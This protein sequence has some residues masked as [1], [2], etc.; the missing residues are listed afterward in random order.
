MN[1][2][3]IVSSDQLF[4]EVDEEL[5]NLFTD[6]LAM[7]FFDN[8]RITTCGH[9]FSANMLSTWFDTKNKHNKSN[10]CSCPLCKKPLRYNIGIEDD[11]FL[12]DIKP[13]LAIQA[14]GRIIKAVDGSTVEKFPINE[15]FIN[16]FVDPISLD[17]I[18]HPVIATCCG[19]LHDNS[20]FS[21]TVR[22][23]GTCDKQN[24]A[25]V[26][27]FTV[28]SILQWMATKNIDLAPHY[29]NL[30][31]SFYAALMAND[32]KQVGLLIDKMDILAEVP[33]IGSDNALHISIRNGLDEMVKLLA[34]RSVNLDK[35]D[36]NGYP[37][38]C[39]AVQYNRVNIVDMLLI[40]G[41]DPERE[42]I[43][44]GNL[45]APQL[46]QQLGLTE[47]IVLFY[48]YYY[49]PDENPQYPLAVE[50]FNRYNS[51]GIGQF[52]LY[53]DELKN[54]NSWQWQEIICGLVYQSTLLVH[55][56]H[57]I[58]VMEELV[59]YATYYERGL[60]LIQACE[61][62]LRPLVQLLFKW[63]CDINAFS[64]TGMRAIFAAI[65]QNDLE[66]FKW[67]TYQDTLQLN[68]KYQNMTPLQY[69]ISL[70][71][72]AFVEILLQLNI[73]VNELDVNGNCPLHHA[74]WSREKELVK[75][76]LHHPEINVDLCTKAT[77]KTAVQLANDL[78][79]DDILV[80]F[81][82]PVV[83]L[84]RL[85]HFVRLRMLKDSVQ[86]LV[87]VYKNFH[88]K[89]LIENLC[90]IE[91]QDMAYYPK[92]CKSLL[93]Q[94][95]DD[96]TQKKE[97]DLF[98][99]LILASSTLDFSHING[100]YQKKY[101]YYLTI[102]LALGKR[103]ENECFNDKL[104][105]LR[106]ELYKNLMEYVHELKDNNPR[107]AQDILLITLTGHNALGYVFKKEKRFLELEGAKKI[108]DSLSQYYDIYFRKNDNQVNLTK[109]LSQLF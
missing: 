101:Y 20:S 86:I 6:P 96:I 81:T 27:H 40:E 74:V 13:D 17:L 59:K 98:V 10:I 76:L 43:P 109:S 67:L 25:V 93:P 69:A 26:E 80:L 88:D 21:G 107:L 12:Y 32:L 66:L 42:T 100:L 82:E 77:R 45:S 53:L 95:T 106:G 24:I 51:W 83:C 56:Q 99:K 38:I 62:N 91:L 55:L 4:I 41:V 7:S 85:K 103:I 70:K 84:A 28:K 97:I 8:A 108:R 65:Q 30:K 9:T 87:E 52:T 15:S 78:Q 39:L 2:K 54:N 68:T 92:I 57:Q 1:Q 29:V 33:L 16:I 18:T 63:G 105:T 75:L 22:K 94:I 47:I 5:I 61:K 102:A 73:N 60:I 48:E 58:E 35:R 3:E 72:I 50:L 79:L 36:S 31:P 71:R 49:P 46:A 90:L 11:E 14:L 104:L 23:C 37:P 19:T 44:D 64:A 34:R 89:V